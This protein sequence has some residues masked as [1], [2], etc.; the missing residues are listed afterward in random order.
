MLWKCLK[1]VGCL[2]MFMLTVRWIDWFGCELGSFISALHDVLVSILLLVLL[3]CL[4]DPVFFKHTGL[5][6]LASIAFCE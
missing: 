5:R 2:V 6:Y 1:R 4:N 3:S